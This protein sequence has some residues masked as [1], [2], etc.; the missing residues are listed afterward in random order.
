MGDRVGFIGV[1]RM[2][3]PMARRLLARGTD[4]GPG[5]ER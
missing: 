2:G 3:G 4:E 1:G 5:R